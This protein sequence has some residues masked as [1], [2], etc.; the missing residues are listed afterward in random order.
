MASVNHICHLCEEEN[1]SNVATIWC[2]ECETFLCKGCERHHSRIKASKRHQ[3]ITLDEYKKL[4]SFIVDIKS[5][6]EKHDEKY[7]FYCK[8]HGDPCCVKCIKDKHKDCRDLDPLVEI[9]RDIKTSAK[10]SNLDKEFNILLEN[11]ETVVKF[12]N[13]RT[14]NLQENKTESLNE[15]RNMRASINKHLDKIEKKMVD[16]LSLEFNKIKLKSDQFNSEI[17]DKKKYI[18]N[19]QEDLSKL[20]MY[21]T[22]LQIF[23]GLQYLEKSASEEVEVL[24]DLQKKGQ[25]DEI[26]LETKFSSDLKCLTDNIST[27]GTAVAHSSPCTLQLKTS[28]KYQVHLSVPPKLTIDNIKLNLTTTLKIPNTFKKK[29]IIGCQILP[30]GRI[31]ILDR[32]STSLLLF[33]KNGKYLEKV[34]VVGSPPSDICYIKHNLIAV[35]IQHRETILLID[36]LKKQITNTIKVSQNSF[37]IDSNGEVLVVNL[38]GCPPTLLTVNLD[39]NILSE[40]KVPG[41]FTIRTALSKNNIVCTDWHNR[42]IYCYTTDGILLWTNKYEDICEPFG[43]TI[44]KNGF[45]FVASRKND[46]IV[47][48]SEDGETSKTILSKE[49][50]IVY[51]FAINIDKSSSTLLVTNSSNVV[52]DSQDKFKVDK[53][54]KRLLELC[55]SLELFLANGRV[56]SD[57]GIGHSTCNYSV[58]DYA[59]VSPTLFR[60]VTDFN[61]LPFDP[62]PSD[63]HNHIC[64]QLFSNIASVNNLNV[65]VDLDITNDSD[66]VI[67]CEGESIVKPRW[68]SD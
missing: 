65:S 7:D 17:E 33:S 50:G 62:V 49:N 48:L 5:R 36:F 63:V 18:Q 66:I 10:V 11:F 54:G 28:G 53:Y 39:G 6:C 23:I 60:A 25:L 14:A 9:L 55:R 20:T 22:D 34:M 44:D 26:R 13:F 61:V 27:F 4:P 31:L 30:D 47:V 58:I 51:P 38:H 35:T 57:R 8:F 15:I 37:G 45:I 59:I 21:A 32:I 24:H 46:K 16:D 19:L 2:A 56:G 41:K 68:A 42:H 43:I 67:A 3:T 1:V 64:L 12:L 40:I 52:R 29:E